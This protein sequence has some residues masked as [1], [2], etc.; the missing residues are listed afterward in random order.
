M[1][2]K[3]TNYDVE[4][5]HRFLYILYESQCDILGGGL[6]TALRINAYDGLRI[7]GTQV[8]PVRIKLYFQAVFGIDLVVFIFFSDLFKDA[9]QVDIIL[10]LYFTLGNK[11]IGIAAS[12]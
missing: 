7:G 2:G 3:N 5:L 4:I 11:I 10:Q 1:G 8:H 9:L 6:K 12:E